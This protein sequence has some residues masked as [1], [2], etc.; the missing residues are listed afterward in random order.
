MVEKY[1]G[2]SIARADIFEAFMFQVGH[3]SGRRYF[4]ADNFWSENFLV[5]EIS[6][7]IYLCAE[8]F[9]SGNFPVG[10]ISGRRYFRAEIFYDIF[11]IFC[12]ISRYFVFLVLRYFGWI[13]CLQ[14]GEMSRVHQSAICGLIVNREIAT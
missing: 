8:K 13:L 4:C 1:P 7:R 9:W 3:I 5:G 2:R 14:V 11:R 10:Y 6:G 12:K